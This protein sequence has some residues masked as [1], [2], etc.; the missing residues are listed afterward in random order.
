LGSFQQALVPELDRIVSDD[1]L[2]AVGRRAD[3][4]LDFPE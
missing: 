1:K 3:G 4:S 2:L